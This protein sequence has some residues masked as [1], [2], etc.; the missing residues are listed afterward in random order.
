MNECWV[1]LCSLLHLIEK[2]NVMQSHIVVPLDGSPLAETILPYAAALA[3]AESAKLTLLHIIPPFSSLGIMSMPIPENWFA[4]E[5]AWTQ[6]YLANVAQRLT[7]G[8]GIH[9]Q[10]EALDGDPATEIISYAH[11]DHKITL[12][13]MTTHGLSSGYRWRFG[14]V[15]A[16]VLYEMPTSMLLLRPQGKGHTPARPVSYHTIVVP[17]DGSPVAEQALGEAQRIATKVGASLLLL[18]VMP[19]SQESTASEYLEHIAQQ[20]RVQGLTVETPVNPRH[21][22]EELPQI[23]MGL[24]HHAGM[25]IMTSPGHD[26]V[27]RLLL[28]SVAEK[29]LQYSEVPV[30]LTRAQAY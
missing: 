6:D 8:V 23:G 3:R 15:T 13:A 28:K 27:E 1:R 16:K 20:L 30:L 18:A 4:Q 7:E 21:T 2:G 5:M 19:A 11:H 25:V 12:N 22:L 14:S 29:F 17:L 26:S 9:V 10:T 24:Q